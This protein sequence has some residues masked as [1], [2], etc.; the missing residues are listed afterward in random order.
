MVGVKGR[1]RTEA[2]VAREREK[3]DLVQESR[4]GRVEAEVAGAE[5]RAMV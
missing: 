1:R 3:V 5:V 2:Q 4:Q